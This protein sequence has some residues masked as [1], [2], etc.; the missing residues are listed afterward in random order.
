MTEFESPI[1]ALCLR[2]ET[3]NRRCV[4]RRAC[5]RAGNAQPRERV[6]F[7]PRPCAPLRVPGSAVFE[8]LGGELRGPLPSGALKYSEPDPA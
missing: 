7:I 1:G 6:E 5:R 2:E 4:F 8:L 3:C